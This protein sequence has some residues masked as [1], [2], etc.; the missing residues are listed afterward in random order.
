[1]HLIIKMFN[2]YKDVVT[3]ASNEEEMKKNTLN[4]IF[5]LSQ[6][7]RDSIFIEES[8]KILS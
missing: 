3:K 8:K 2:Y 7:E 1:M 6:E 5:N 4:K